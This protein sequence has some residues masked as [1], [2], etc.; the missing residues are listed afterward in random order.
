MRVYD[1]QVEL[2]LCCRIVHSRRGFGCPGPCRCLLLLLPLL[3][4]RLAPAALLL[5][6]L[7]GETVVSSWGLIRAA[8]SLIGVAIICRQAV[9]SNTGSD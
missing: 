7:L 5:L 1:A 9:N 6:L 4:A 2:S 3:L 8:T